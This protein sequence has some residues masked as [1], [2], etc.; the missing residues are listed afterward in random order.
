[1]GQKNLINIET[2]LRIAD[3]FCGDSKSNRMM[4]GAGNPHLH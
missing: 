3:P 4:S 2:V 1:M